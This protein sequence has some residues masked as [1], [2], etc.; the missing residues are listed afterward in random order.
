MLFGDSNESKLDKVE[1]L[2][3]RGFKSC[4]ERVKREVKIG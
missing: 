1:F 4:S 2:V 3:Y